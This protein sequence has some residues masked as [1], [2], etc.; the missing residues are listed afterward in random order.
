M[1]F[2]V[3]LGVRRDSPELLGQVNAALKVEQMRIHELL[4]EY[5][6]LLLAGCPARGG[7]EG[8]SN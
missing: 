1:T 6:F 5:H 7:G 3:R 4:G 8:T 2:D